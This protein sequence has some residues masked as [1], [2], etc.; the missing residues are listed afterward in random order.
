MLREEVWQLVEESHSSGKFLPALNATFL[1]LIPK[2][3]RVTNPR[4]FIPIALCNLIYKI[5]SKVTALRIKPI[6]PFIISKEQ[7]GYVEGRQTMDSFMLVHEIIHSLKITHTPGMLLKLELSK[8]F[9]KLSWQYMNA[10]LSYFSFDKDWVSW[11][12]NLI[13]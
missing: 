11:I 2:E 12:M 6:L 3:E 1:T 10:L 5:I 9:D 8:D 13:S 7:S 4:N